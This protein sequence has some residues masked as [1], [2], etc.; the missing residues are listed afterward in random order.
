MHII[1]IVLVVFRAAPRNLWCRQIADPPFQ[2]VG[3]DL[4]EWPQCVALES[5]R[6]NQ[7][8]AGAGPPTTDPENATRC[9]LLVGDPAQLPPS[10]GPVAYCGATVSM[11]LS[12]FERCVSGRRHVC[13]SLRHQYRMRPALF[14]IPYL[15]FYAG[16]TG[17]R[18]QPHSA[19]L[20]ALDDP[21]GHPS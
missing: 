15:L 11:G 19:R 8:S 14:C 16:S 5:R 7:T 3:R 12:A 6:S 1:L 20:V 21:V 10:A 9:V 2:V 13:T 4:A 17:P 18:H